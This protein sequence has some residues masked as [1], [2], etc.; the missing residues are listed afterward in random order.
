MTFI[1]IVQ[2]LNGV[3]VFA[4]G[5]GILKWA[6]GVERRL[7]RVEIHAGFEGKTS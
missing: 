2:L 1:E 7:M 3:G 4:G 5:V 6:L